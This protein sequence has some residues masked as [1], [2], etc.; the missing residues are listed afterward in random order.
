MSVSKVRH[1]SWST[2]VVSMLAAL[3]LSGVGVFA[4]A[5]P[6]SAAPSDCGLGLHCSYSGYDYGNDAL[7]Q[8]STHKFENC[9]DDMYIGWR[10]YNNVTS[11]AFNNG[12]SQVSY[13]YSGVKQTGSRLP[14]SKGTGK[15][16]LSSYAFNDVADSG[17]FHSTL[18]SKGSALC[19]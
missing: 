8:P 4:L 6:A 17:Y 5:G 14:F 7:Q 10:S 16:N 12:R 3:A 2:R 13:L 19:R 18:G 9:V 1:V 15:A 11:S